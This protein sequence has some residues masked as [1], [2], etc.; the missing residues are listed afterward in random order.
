L[1]PEQES[2][3]DEAV[4]ISML[5]SL[6]ASSAP[7]IKNTFDKFKEQRFPIKK[8]TSKGGLLCPEQESNADEALPISMLTSP[9]ASSAPASKNI[10]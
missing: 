7:A 1:C 6:M 8:T 9:K 10:F 4:P 5:T 2:N 3:A